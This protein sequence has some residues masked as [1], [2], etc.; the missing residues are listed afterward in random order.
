[1]CYRQQVDR[2]LDAADHA[3]QNYPPAVELNLPHL[4][5]GDMIFVYEAQG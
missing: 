1:M 5:I 2:H 4:L 3:P